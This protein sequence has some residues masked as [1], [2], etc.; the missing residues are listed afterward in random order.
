[1]DYNPQTGKRIKS[2]I[3]WVHCELEKQGQLTGFNLR[4]CLFGEHQLMEGTVRSIGI[5]E[6]EKTAILA[7]AYLPELTWMASGSLNGL[8]GERLS[9][10]KNH[11]I[12]LYPDIK[13]FDKWR[14]KATE[15][16]KVGFRVTVSDLLEKA[17]FVTP[18]E[19]NAGFD[20]ADYLPRLPLPLTAIEIMET[21][22]PMLT[23]LI[24]KL[25]LIELN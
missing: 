2:R 24:N 19:R 3:T 21:K 1:M 9:P 11:N 5:V 13:G 23:E 14:E 6:S 16:K 8:S 25:D 10:I 15:L 22:N 4:Q 17:D 18:E 12:I 20:L 7:T